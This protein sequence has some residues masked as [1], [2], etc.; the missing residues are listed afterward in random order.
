MKE[1]RFPETVGERSTTDTRFIT[2]PGNNLKGIGRNP[3]VHMEKEQ[4]L[5]LC[6]LC[7]G[8]HLEAPACLCGEKVQRCGKSAGVVPDDRTG[9]V[10]TAPVYNDEFKGSRKPGK[11]V[12]ERCDHIFFVQYRCNNGDELHTWFLF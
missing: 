12:K 2:C 1:T 10:S 9:Q 6:G 4:D 8:V 11:M 5:S 7:T 3:A